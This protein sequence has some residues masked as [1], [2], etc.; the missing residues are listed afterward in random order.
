MKKTIPQMIPLIIRGIAPPAALA[1]GLMSPLAFGAPGDLDPAFGNAGVSSSLFSGAAWAEEALGANSV[2]GGGEEAESCF[3]YFYCSPE[4][5]DGTLGQI[6]GSG[7]LA[8]SSD[9]A[10]LLTT[11]VFDL[12]AQADGKVVAV[13]RT[14]ESEFQK[15]LTI[16]RLDGTGSLDPTF[17]K[18]GLVQLNGTGA[19]TAVALE[20][21]GRI[22]VAGSNNSKLIVLR[23]MASGDFDDS[24]AKSGVFV[25]PANDFSARNPVRTRLLRTL[26][27]GYRVTINSDK[28]CQIL[29]L[30]ANGAVDASFGNQGSSAFGFT[31][32]SA[33]GA[34]PD[35]G[36]LVAGRDN[37]HGMAA[38]LLAN[39]ATD[40]S[41]AADAVSGAM[42]DATALAIRDDGSI[43]IAGRSSAGVSGA[44][45]LQLQANGELDILFGDHGS[46]WI[47]PP[48]SLNAS[49]RIHEMQVRADGAVLAVGGDYDGARGSAFAA[50]L[51]GP[52]GGDGPGV[53]G[54]K[55]PYVL[56][57]EQGQQA[58]VTVRRS[59]GQAGSISVHYQT[60]DLIDQP[61]A[62]AGQDYTPVSGRLAWAD[63]DTTDRQI[64]VP[65]ADNEA[66]EEYELF[67][68]EL[69]DVQGGAGLGTH[70]ADV[71]ILPDG[72]P[73]GQFSVEVSTT[74]V[75]EGQT[76]QLQVSRNFY[77]SGPV[78]VTLTPV[79]GS[80]IAG[81]DFV[82][83]PITLSWADGD[84]QSIPVTIAISADNQTESVESFSVQLSNP[85]G[86]AIL[87]SRSSGT[88]IINADPKPPPPSNSGGGGL[89]DCV[90][91]L[92]LTFIGLL[93]LSWTAI[94]GDHA[95]S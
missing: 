88:I 33:L 61:P 16:F 55:F 81:I 71:E 29:A 73:F 89:I 43:L 64:I 38:R 95:H 62:T 90:S 47:D 23:L 37:E 53:L 39:G 74:S 82:S 7:V 78:S 44:T 34:Q 67:G 35:G 58:V 48:S 27:A 91:L 72:S 14:I 25:G 87:G 36:L 1:S 18:A 84:S 57:E 68:I 75:I 40:P 42:D 2:V 17:G 93:R 15:R 79:A 5:A 26:E 12:V 69:D 28:G 41:F 24:F 76:A 10:I 77:S 63:G 54:M 4:F 56:T 83:D 66:P 45:V 94:R 65:I 20:P 51:L 8:S 6:S 92:W 80:A 86:G 30:T 49:A 31:L 50:R 85:T 70:N 11:M 9:A 52:A 19:A 32:C 59:G 46:T 13:G 22:L 21:D 3:F 60:R